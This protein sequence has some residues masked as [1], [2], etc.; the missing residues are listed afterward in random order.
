[1]E[2]ATSLFK[3][4]HL[5]V[6]ITND[7]EGHPARIWAGLTADRLVGCGPYLMGQKAKQARDL[8]NRIAEVLQPLYGQPRRPKIDRAIELIQQA[9][10]DTPW[11]QS[12]HHPQLVALIRMEIERN[13]NTIYRSN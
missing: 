6:L 12:F 1:M 10:G 8:K 5:T 9:A 13:L 3:A 4:G 2:S 11:A 7:D